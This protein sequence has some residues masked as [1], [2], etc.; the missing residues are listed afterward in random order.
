MESKQNNINYK[1]ILGSF[2]PLVAAVLAQYIVN[3]LDVIILFVSNLHSSEKSNSTMT[4]E[5]IMQQDYNQPMNLAYMTFAQHIVFIL[6]FG[7]WYY[8]AFYT[9]K[10]SAGETLSGRTFLSLNTLF[11]ILAG[12]SCQVMV[13]GI[14]TL[15]RPCFPAAFAEYDKLVSGVSGANTAAVMIIAV[16]LFAPIGEELLFRGLVQGY[17]KRYMPIGPAILFQGIL[18]GIYH[19][20][21]IQGIYACILGCIL[22]YVAYKTK[23]VISGMILHLCINASLY[24]V[25]AFWFNGTTRCAIVTAASLV[26]FCIMIW[27]VTRS[28]KIEKKQTGHN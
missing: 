8:K 12:F 1:D 21:L 15:I 3:F 19:G 2:L 18:F 22:G 13:D 11:L 6:C 7:I 4:I 9:K 25:P 28:K 16:V 20:N 14:L 10:A 27:L 5:T 24:I 17:A 23:N 26:V